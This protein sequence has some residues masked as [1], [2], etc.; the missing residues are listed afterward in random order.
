MCKDWRS[1][2]LFMDKWIQN[3]SIPMGVSKGFVFKGW[4][5]IGLYHRLIL[6]KIFQNSPFSI[7]TL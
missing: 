7:Y 5:W 4:Q 1:E 2:S 6:P 3:N